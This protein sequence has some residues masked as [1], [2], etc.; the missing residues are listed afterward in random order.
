M[1]TLDPVSGVVPTDP[2]LGWVRPEWLAEATAWI[3][4]RLEERG[5]ERTG[6]IEQ[7]HVRWWST[8]LRIPTGGGTLWFK[9]N[10]APGRTQQQF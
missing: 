4:S 6:G 8:V 7:P 3:A 1:T 2:P 9:A 5:L 10:A